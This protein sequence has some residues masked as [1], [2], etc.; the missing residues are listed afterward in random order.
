MNASLEIALRYLRTGR[1]GYVSFITWVSFFGLLLGV[2]VLTVVVSVMNGF[3]H[4]LKTRLLQAIPHVVID[5]LA[6][7]TKETFDVPDVIARYPYFETVGMVGRGN[8]VQ[9]VS[10]LGLDAA[11]LDAMQDV[12]TGMTS[13]DLHT[14]LVTPGN[15]V[16]GAPLARHLGVGAG[17]RVAVTLPATSGGKVRPQVLAFRLGG[18]FS[19]GSELD[20]GLVLVAM[21]DIPESIRASSGER[22]VQLRLKNPLDAERI[23][24]MLQRILPEARITTWMERYGELFRAVQLEKAMMFVLLLLVVT[25]AAFNIISGQVM[26]IREKASAI[27]I[28]RTMGARASQ[29]STIFLLQGIIIGIAGIASG[30]VLGV[31]A[32]ININHI[33]AALESLFGVSFL[34]GTYFVEI[35]YQIQPSDLGLIAGL[36][37]GICLLAAWIP[38]QRAKRVHPIQ[39]L[40]GF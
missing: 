28:L 24:G 35:P 31:F 32:T 30:L 18:T 4:E 9:P 5:D 25:V 36:A 17:D 6:V 39:G 23:R 10:L 38:A 33:V 12:G 22:G 7:L 11:G 29:V 34:E 19:L 8:T 27:A 3:D 37:G 15:L 16:L 14:L 1:Q 21:R 40:H 2:L 26:L 13:G 20:Y